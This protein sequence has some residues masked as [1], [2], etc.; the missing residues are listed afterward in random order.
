MQQLDGVRKKLG[1]IDSDLKDYM[2]HLI[3]YVNISKQL[4]EATVSAASTQS[5][6]TGGQG[7]N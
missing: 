6:E 2:D 7:E 4:E 5:Q 3:A 1:R